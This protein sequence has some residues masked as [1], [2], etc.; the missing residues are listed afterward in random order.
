MAGAGIKK[1]TVP[2]SWKNKNVVLQF[3]AINH[4]SFIYVNGIKVDENIG[5][6]F[7]NFLLISLEN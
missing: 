3:G 7:N 4:T 6:G 2:K 5:D 1:L